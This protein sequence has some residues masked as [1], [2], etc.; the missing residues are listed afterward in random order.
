M[1]TIY[2]TTIRKAQITDIKEIFNLV[3][4]SSNWMKE[5]YGLTHW[6]TYYSIE[7]IKELFKTLSFYIIFA[8]HRPVGTY[9]VSTTPPSYYTEK[10]LSKFTNTKSTAYY[11]TALCVLPEYHGHGFAKILIQHLEALAKKNDVKYIRFDARTAYTELISFYKKL[12]FKVVGE[13]SDEGEA[14]SLF[15]KK[16]Q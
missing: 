1:E 11:G 3:S 2:K 14:Y 5:T 13:L 15:E 8:N 10:D 12:D 16:I 6:D 7:K 4:T 9:A